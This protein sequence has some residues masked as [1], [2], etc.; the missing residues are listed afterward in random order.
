MSASGEEYA[1]TGTMPRLDIVDCSA[2][3]QVINICPNT[4]FIWD[5]I[6]TIINCHFS[7]SSKVEL[8]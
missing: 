1:H 8:M 2:E 5:D 4:I 6:W 7:S 3:T